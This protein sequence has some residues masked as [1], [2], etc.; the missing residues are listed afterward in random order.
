MSKRAKPRPKAAELV[1]SSYQPTKRDKAE[2]F[3]IDGPGDTIEER[4]D[5]LG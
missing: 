2:E 3:A 1:K 4:M 5:A